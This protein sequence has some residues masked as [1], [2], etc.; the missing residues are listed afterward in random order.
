MAKKTRCAK[1]GKEAQALTMVLTIGPQGYRRYPLCDSCKGE[2]EKKRAASAAT[3][4]RVSRGA[5]NG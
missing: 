1:C 4:A 3:H 2:A 5:K